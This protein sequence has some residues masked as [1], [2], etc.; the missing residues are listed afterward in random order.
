MESYN[1]Y[2]PLG[3]FAVRDMRQ[4][5]AVGIIK[6]VDKT[7]KTGGK[8][9]LLLACASCSMVLTFLFVSDEVC[10]EGG[11]EEV[12]CIEY[13]FLF[14]V[15]FPCFSPSPCMVSVAHANCACLSSNCCI[16]DDEVH[17]GL[18]PECSVMLCNVV[19]NKKWHCLYR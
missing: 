12:N 10:G 17:R 5:V 6:S 8:G 3:R 7:E 2:P 13:A 15:S 14:Q 11:Q 16:H 18:L 1:E 4:T 19:A 9:E